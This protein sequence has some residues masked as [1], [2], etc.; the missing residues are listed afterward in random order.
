M[1]MILIAFENVF[2]EESK[3]GD[4]IAEEDENRISLVVPSLSTTPWK[5]K[6]N[7]FRVLNLFMDLLAI[8]WR[9]IMYCAE[10]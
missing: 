3:I 10:K 9:F 8:K 6:E 1:T 5:V 2:D 7:L 4:D